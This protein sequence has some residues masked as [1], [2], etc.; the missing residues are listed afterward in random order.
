MFLRFK[1]APALLAGL[2]VAGCGGSDS[3]SGSG[4]G[5]TIP[6]TPIV[7]VDETSFSSL[8]KGSFSLAL[9][10]TGEGT[11]PGDKNFYVQIISLPCKNSTPCDATEKV[12]SNVT[13]VRTLEKN[14]PNGNASLGKVI[15]ATANTDLVPFKLSD[16]VNGN[17]ILPGDAVYDGTR[18]YISVGAP[19]SMKVAPDGRG[20]VQP[21]IESETGKTIPFDFIEI[22]YDAKPKA[23]KPEENTVAF[24]VN[25]TQVDQFVMPMAFT[26]NGVSG[27]TKKRGITIG[28]GSS[29]GLPTR[30][31]IIQLYLSS[32]SDPFKT[33]LQKHNGENIRILSPFH[34][35]VFQAGGSEANFFDA[36]VT[37]TWNYYVGKTVDIYDQPNNAGNRYQVSSNGTVLNVTA[38]D[39]NGVNQGSFTMAK[40]TSLDVFKNVG[41]LQPGGGWPNA[42]GAM[43]SGALNR[44]V[45]TQPQNWHI[46]SQY[47]QATPK[48]D[49][50]QFWHPISI[51]NL[52]YGFGFDD[53]AGQSSFAA[54]PS[55]ENI[56]SLD[57]TI[58]W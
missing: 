25:M 49:Y 16:L 54:L 40:P 32:V 35:T 23:A 43:L 57:V 12:V 29:S 58:G 19:L 39:T 41:A 6:F 34:G 46:P 5:S 42:F 20:Y 9:T 4:S 28:T 33:L 55:T 56:S 8:P 18:I 27:T 1:L 11:L 48:H 50:A 24:G 22:A 31:A 30:E 36:Y 7:P 3:N 53:T 26:L 17:I 38:F 51:D 10:R 45:A 14:G 13:L 2:L 44:H 21:N 15:E 37:E 52:A 47:Y